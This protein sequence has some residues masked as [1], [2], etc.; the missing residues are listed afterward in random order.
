[1]RA[2]KAGQED[3]DKFAKEIARQIPK[4]VTAVDSHEQELAEMQF[5]DLY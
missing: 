3:A 1:M 5:K 4:L 2:K